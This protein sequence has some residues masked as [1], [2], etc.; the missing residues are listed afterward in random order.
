MVPYACISENEASAGDGIPGAR[1]SRPPPPLLANLGKASAMGYLGDLQVSMM[2]MLSSLP[3]LSFQMY[4][5][6][7]GDERTLGMFI[8]LTKRSGWN[9]V[10]IFSIPGSVRK[11]ILA[12]PA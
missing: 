7:N 2:P 3:H 8:E 12:V 9:I 4:V 10:E 6:L 11:Q 5:A 1:E